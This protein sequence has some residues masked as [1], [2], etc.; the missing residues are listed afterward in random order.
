MDAPNLDRPGGAFP[1]GA[2]S[3]VI[4]SFLSTD[5]LACLTPYSYRVN[6]RRTLEMLRSVV[7]AGRGRQCLAAPGRQRHTVAAC[8]LR[9]P[10]DHIALMLSDPD[11]VTAATRSADL[12]RKVRALLLSLVDHAAAPASTTRVN[13]VTARPD[14]ST[15][16]SFSSDPMAVNRSEQHI[17]DRLRFTRYEVGVGQAR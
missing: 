9:P 10:R 11:V 8:L 13:T 12:L 3:T 7:R 14:R 15:S 2:A 17:N 6:L 5:H 16:T 4:T 1:D